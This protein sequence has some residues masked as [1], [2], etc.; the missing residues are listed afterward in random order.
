MGYVFAVLAVL[1]FVGA[2]RSNVRMRELRQHGIRTSG[3]VVG[4][5][6]VKSDASSHGDGHWVPVIAFTDMRGQQVE[7]K[8]R[9]TGGGLGLPTGQHVPVVY[10]PDKPKSACVDTRRHMMAS[11]RFWLLVGVIEAFVAVLILVQ[12]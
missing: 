9:V 3:V 5:V 11:V 7:F 4:Q 1:C 8:P 2:L 10:L 6:H 12:P